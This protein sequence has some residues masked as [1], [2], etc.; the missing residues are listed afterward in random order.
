MASAGEAYGPS[1]PLMAKPDHRKEFLNRH[2]KGG[3]RR[4]RQ[5]TRHRQLASPGNRLRSDTRPGCSGHLAKYIGLPSHLQ[6]GYLLTTY[7][8]KEGNGAMYP[9]TR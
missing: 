6:V 2:L 3:L 4:H 9:Q 8:K 1:R 5:A 7:S